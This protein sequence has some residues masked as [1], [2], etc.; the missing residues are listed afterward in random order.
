MPTSTSCI[1][2]MEDG[3]LGATPKAPDAIEATFA[4]RF[5]GQCPGCDPRR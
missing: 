2:C 5:E 1:T 4:A 3:G